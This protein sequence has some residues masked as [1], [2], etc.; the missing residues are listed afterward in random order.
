MSK[1]AIYFPSWS[2]PWVADPKNMTL[3]K[4]EVDIAYIAFANPTCNYSKGQKNFQGTG[5]EFSQDFSVVVEAIKILTSKGTKVMLSVGGGAY[6]S[7]TKEF[8]SYSCVQL[9]EDLGCSGIDI[10]W[11]GHADKDYELTEAIKILKTNMPSGKYISFAGFSTGAYGKDGDT[12][13]GNAINAMV[14]CGSVV[15]WINIMAYDAGPN[16]D[17]LGAFE[18]YKIYYSGPLY[19]GFEPGTQAWGGHVITEEEVDRNVHFVKSQGVKHGIFIWCHG[20]EGDG[21]PSA[22]N[23]LAASKTIFG[24]TYTPIKPL[25]TFEA[26]ANPGLV[27]SIVCPV[28][29]TKYSGSK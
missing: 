13:K 1:T 26:P 19:L 16:Y 4:L 5:L 15:D 17:P 18:C 21:G 20:K 11:E 24:S 9:M 27:V 14:N 29:H 12:Y 28:C 10:D 23:V 8:N 2:A 6:W 25:P 22:A 3:A 7:S